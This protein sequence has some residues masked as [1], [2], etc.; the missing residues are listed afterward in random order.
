MKRPIGHRLDDCTIKAT[1]KIVFLPPIRLRGVTVAC[2][3][4]LGAYTYM[5]G[6]RLGGVKSV[7]NYCS[8]APNVSI[9]DGQHPLA[10]LSTHLFQSKGVGFTFWPEFKE[11][12]TETKNVKQ[13]AA[14]VIGSDVWIGANAVVMRGVKIGHGAV[15]GAGAVVTRDVRPFEVVGGVPARHIKFRFDDVCGRLCGR[16]IICRLLALRWW[17][18]S[19]KSLEG[20]PFHDI[21]AA[22]RELERRKKAGLLVPMDKT[23]FCYENGKVEPWGE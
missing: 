2:S 17:D 11:F 14:V 8:I 13:R 3:P 15:I 21:K 6:G 18:Y 20:V 4:K 7:G 1:A 10:Y 22:V 16:L 5:R 23:L 12:T 19:L 9:G